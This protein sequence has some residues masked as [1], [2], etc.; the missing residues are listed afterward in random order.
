MQSA[1]WG[2]GRMPRLP[3]ALDDAR[4]SATTQPNWPVMY[5]SVR[6]SLGRENSLSVSSYSISVP[7]RALVEAEERRLVGD[8]HR[9]LHVVRDDHDR[10]LAT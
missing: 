9:L 6:L 3:L 5:A 8:A 2:R 7:M 4:D 1:E 10:V